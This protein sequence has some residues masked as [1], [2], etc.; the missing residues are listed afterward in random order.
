M[1]K[2][3]SALLLPVSNEYKQPLSLQKIFWDELTGTS[4]LWPNQYKTFGTSS[5][6]PGPGTT[7]LYFWVSPIVVS[8]QDSIADAS[9]R[10]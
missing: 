2:S 7:I 9:G 1:R 5:T 6:C 4:L 8:E 3:V 10:I